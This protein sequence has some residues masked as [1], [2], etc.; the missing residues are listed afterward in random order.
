MT[1]T[2]TC[3]A[4]PDSRSLDPA[5]LTRLDVVGPLL[6]ER[7]GDPSWREARAELVAGGKSNLTFRVR[8][9][10]GTVVLRRPPTGSILPKAHDMGREARV[11]Q[12]LAGTD[13]PVAPILLAHDETVTGFRFY[14]MAEVKGHVIRDTLP[15]GYAESPTDL[16]T[17]THALVDTLA[18]LHEVDPHMVGL[19]DYGRPEGF[20]GR[21]VRLWAR[22]WEQAKTAD[23]PVVDELGKALE[24]RVPSGG[25]ASIVHGDYRLD[26]VVMNDADPGDLAAVL[27]WELSTLGDPLTDLGMLLFYWREPGDRRMTIIPHLTADAG[28]PGRGEVRDR[29]SRASGQDLADLAFYEALAHFKFAAITQGIAARVAAG[30][31]GGQDFGG[32]EDEVACTAEAGLDILRERT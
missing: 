19:G 1:T 24:K 28:F 27:D 15:A 6:Q 25:N 10:A 3:G 7:L 20:A 13:V 16:R 5:V 4:T 30:A 29:Y 8:S 31:M 22:Q 14:V 32:L 2:T 26:N 9:A 12:A 23:V 17:M 21:Q 18:R 11:Q